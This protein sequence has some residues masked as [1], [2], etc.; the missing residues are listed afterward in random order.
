[1]D[2]VQ[3][4]HEAATELINRATLCIQPA[5]SR[6]LLIQAFELEKEAALALTDS[7]KTT[8]MRSKLFYESIKLAILLEKFNDAKELI[9]VAQNGAIHEDYLDLIKNQAEILSLVSKI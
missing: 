2:N 3:E 9:T 6:I 5:E 4:L 1:M 8:M 7:T